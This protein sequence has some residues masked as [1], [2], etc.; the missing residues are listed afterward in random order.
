MEEKNS[1]WGQKCSKALYYDISSVTSGV[2]EQ[3]VAGEGICVLV[4]GRARRNLLS[5]LLSQ[6]LLWFYHSI[7]WALKSNDEMR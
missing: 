5:A 7:F 3:G 2:T 4:L 1:G 6:R